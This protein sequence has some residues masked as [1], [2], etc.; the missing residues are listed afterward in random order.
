MAERNES[1]TDL[2]PG[3]MVTITALLREFFM[4]HHGEP[5]PN[6][7]VTMTEAIVLFG[8]RCYREG[9]IAEAKRAG[10]VLKSL[11]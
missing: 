1:T 6:I 8:K 3:A 7:D 11:P 10:A 9:Q 4:F 2:G 5:V